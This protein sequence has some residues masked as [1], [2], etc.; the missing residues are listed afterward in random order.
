MHI[1]IFSPQTGASLGVTQ[2]LDFKDIIQDQH[3]TNPIVLRFVPDQE[4]SVS[5]LKLYLENKGMNKNSNFFF[6]TSSIFFPDIESG[7]GIFAPFI[8]VPGVDSIVAPY[9]YTID[10]PVI[11][12]GSFSGY[13]WL[14]VQS[15]NQIGVNQPNFRLFFDFS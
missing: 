8:E 2:L 3:C 14:D 12:N 13:V 7:S 5:N 11:P 1:E 10:P 4:A 6:A 9:G 15:L